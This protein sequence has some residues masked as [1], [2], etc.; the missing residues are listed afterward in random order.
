MRWVVDK[1]NNIISMHHFPTD[2]SLED[3]QRTFISTMRRRHALLHDTLKTSSSLMLVCNRTNSTAEFEQFL[4]DFSGLYKNLRITLMNI[5][6]DNSMGTFDKR[7]N[8]HAISERLTIL[9]HTF[10]DSVNRETG[11][12]YSWVGN[13]TMW[14]AVLRDYC[15]ADGNI[16]RR[17]ERL[18]EKRKDRKL[19]IYGAGNMCS[20]L[21]AQLDKYGIRADGIAVTKTEGN[22]LEHEHLP[23]SAIGTVPHDAVILM[24][25]RNRSASSAIKKHLLSEGRTAV[26]DVDFTHGV[27]PNSGDIEKL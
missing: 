18:S 21:K 23:V 20:A 16:H 13:R 11:E 4:L 12:K 1:T 25:I 5:R 22:P 6:N 8:T 27:I 9:E 14:N 26:V 10:N 3:S 17:F 19:I 7:T 15:L 24:A 2:I